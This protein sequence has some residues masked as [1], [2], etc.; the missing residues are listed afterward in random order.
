VFTG[1]SW[2]QGKYYEITK[3]LSTIDFDANGRIVSI[4]QGKV[5]ARIAHVGEE[6]VCTSII[7]AGELRYGA[8]RKGSGR[9]ATYHYQKSC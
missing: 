3:I 7:L 9:R 2:I 5:A 8:A 6:S 1:R 4:P